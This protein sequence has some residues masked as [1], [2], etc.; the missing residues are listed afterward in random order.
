[1]SNK[2]KFI[3]WL[4]ITVNAVNVVVLFKAIFPTEL[5]SRD[6]CALPLMAFYFI[7]FVISGFFIA[8]LTKKEQY[9]PTLLLIA[10]SGVVLIIFIAAIVKS[11]DVAC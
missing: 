9:R 7:P 6:L 8:A 2:N 10:A 4:L 5:D 11:T 3:T 1:M